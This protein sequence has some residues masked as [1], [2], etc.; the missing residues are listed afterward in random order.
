MRKKAII[1]IA[2]ACLLL[3]GSC[4][5]IFAIPEVSVTN[6]FQ[7]GI[8]DIGIKEYTINSQGERV[9]WNDIDGVLPGMKIS[10][11]PQITN[12]GADCYVRVKISFDTE[13]IAEDDIYGLNEG[14]AK[15]E[16]GYYYYKNILESG[17]EVDLFEGVIIPEDLPQEKM[18][19]KQI[20]LKI[21]ADAIQSTNFSPD[22]TSEAPWGQVQIQ[23]CKEE[24]YDISTLKAVDHAALNIEYRG[25]I[26]KLMANPDDFFTNLPYLMPGDQFSDTAILQNNSNNDIR[27]YFR[28]EI[29]R[30]D[31]VLEK[32]ILTIKYVQ[33]GDARTIYKGPLKG[34]GITAS[35]Y[36]GTIEAGKEGNF[37]FVL[38]VP[39][40]L[41]NDYSLLSSQVKW[42]FATEEIPSYPTVKTGDDINVGKI[43]SLFM[44]IIG[45]IIIVPLIYVNYKRKK[46]TYSKY[47]SGNVRKETYEDK[48]DIREEASE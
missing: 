40:E 39:A 8:V 47:R 43:V 10:K 16:D 35:T 41:N 28:N 1:L 33:N 12:Y 7:T 5:V 44:S 24:E 11:I 45:I 19:E 25:D 48:A 22:F 3:C 32:I 17:E 13:T 31:A 2:V 21:D 38:D 36:L 29:I 46:G 27:I 9:E 15:S 14:W 6:F 4:A 23:K 18:E 26:K 30:D 20:H 37:I 34:D 42:I